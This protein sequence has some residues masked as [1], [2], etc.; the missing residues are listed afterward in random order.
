VKSGRPGA[1]NKK[2]GNKPARDIL[3][4]LAARWKEIIPIAALNRDRLPKIG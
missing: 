2:A 1:Q 4:K 3:P